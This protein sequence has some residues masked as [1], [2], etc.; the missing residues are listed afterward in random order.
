MGGRVITGLSPWG[1]GLGTP[2]YSPSLPQP[3]GRG[4]GLLAWS[5][6]VRRAG[7]LT[8]PLAALLES[9]TP[10]SC[11]LG[12]SLPTSSSA[13]GRPGS[14]PPGR[15]AG[16]RLRSSGLG[17]SVTM[18]PLGVWLSWSAPLSSTE[19]PKKTG[20]SRRGRLEMVMGLCLRAATLGGGT[21]GAALSSG[22]P[23]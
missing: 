9:F 22:G 11:S 5:V 12:T 10:P 20:R 13:D 17:A 7:L 4:A 8:T 16:R 1:R 6:E 18:L 19:A 3:P 2:S 15:G 23:E 21:G 14:S